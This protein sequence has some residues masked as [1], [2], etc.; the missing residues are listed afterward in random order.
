M[1][2]PYL[3]EAVVKSCLHAHYRPLVP[4]AASSD[5]CISADYPGCAER[6]GEANGGAHA[7]CPY[8]DEALM[9]FCS[10][11]AV[12]KLV[13]YNESFRFRC[14]ADS[15]RYCEIYLQAEP[16]PEGR[17]VCVE[18]IPVPE[19][20]LY[21][22]NHLWLAAGEDGCCH[23][24]IDAFFA[25]ALKRV[26]QVSFLTVSGMARPSAVLTARGVDVLVTF[27]VAVR[28]TASNLYLRANPAK[29]TRD[30]YRRGWLFE[31]EDDAGTPQHALMSGAAAV[32]WMR[33]EVERMR[34]HP[35]PE[36]REELIRM[37]HS[38]FSPMADLEQKT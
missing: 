10:A 6:P 28:I 17:R 24:G 18:S 12:R 34:R 31:V 19:D 20:L 7:R 8:L 23:I 33:R 3:Q 15:H 9:Q 27:P 35:P 2:C 37:F 4:G 11:A 32:A 30:P 13:P 29:L 21:S 14:L 38:F 16:G 22:R 5:R 25:R 36:G 1:R 26:E